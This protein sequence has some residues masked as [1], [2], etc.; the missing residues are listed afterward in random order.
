[1]YTMVTTVENTVDNTISY[2]KLLR[3]QIK[4][5][6]TRKVFFIIMWG[7]NVKLIVITILQYIYIFHYHLVHWCWIQCYVSVISQ[8]K[9]KTKGITR[10]LNHHVQIQKVKYCLF[11]WFL[12][13]LHSK[14]IELTICFCL[15]TIF[16]LKFI[17]S[18]EDI[19][20]LGKHTHAAAESTKR[21]WGVIILFFLA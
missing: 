5:L 13:I 7:D 9:R 21:R 4:V 17:L 12:I 1:M 2:W 6:I 8:F 16:L 18:C 20:D 3:K 15:L 19:Q 11:P 14:K 10:F